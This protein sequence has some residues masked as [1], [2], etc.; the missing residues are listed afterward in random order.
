MCKYFE[1]DEKVHNQPI[2]HFMDFLAVKMYPKI[3]APETAY[4]IMFVQTCFP[5][6]L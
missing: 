1:Q 4:N 5:H 3:I 2:N 6:Q